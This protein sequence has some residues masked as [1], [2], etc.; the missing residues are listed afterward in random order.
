MTIEPLHDDASPTPTLLSR[1]NVVRLVKF[2]VVGFSGVGVN[3]VIFELFYRLLLT[4]ITPELRLVA[5]NVLGVVVSIFTNFVLN[6]RWTWGDRAKGA[7]RDWFSRLAK[8]YLL[9]SVAAGVQVFVTWASFSAFWEPLELTF[10]GVDLS[11][12]A[13][14]LTGIAF[15]MVI[16]FLASHFWAFR[17]VER[18]E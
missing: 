13:S 8:Y 2:G 11:P 7:G 4:A 14:L 3:L 15:G 1:D 5:A 18:S 9:A 6:D 17:D 12:T 16:N 10:A